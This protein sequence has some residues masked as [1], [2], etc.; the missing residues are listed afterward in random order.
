MN[1]SKQTQPAGAYSRAGFTLIELLVVIS[2]MALLAGL[3]IPVLGA[4]KKHQYLKTARAE[5][6]QIASA[7]DNYKAKYGAYPPSYPNIPPVW[8]TLYYEL[9]GV[10]HDNIA[11]TNITLDGSCPISDAA[12]GNAF[13]PGKMGGI[14]NST[15]D[16]GEDST[17][18]K[19]FLLGMRANRYGTSLLN[20]V[21]ITNL[22]TSV[23]GPDAGY[24]PVGVQDV[25]P[26]RYVYPGTNNTKSYD[27]WIDLSIK[28]QTNRLS[29]WSGQVQ[30]IK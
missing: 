15:K 16:G 28:G 8:N 3:T 24:Q 5:L 25:N 19:N 20:G 9:S 29:N 11:K 26:F 2:I 4:V 1:I 13:T 22:V 21:W 23:R 14:V 30:I 27:L 6:E 18:A 7:L 10:I 17:S 12:Y